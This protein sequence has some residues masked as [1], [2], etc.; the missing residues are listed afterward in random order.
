MTSNTW[1]WQDTH[2]TATC[3]SYMMQGSPKS[4][5]ICSIAMPADATDSMAGWRD[6][7]VRNTCSGLGCNGVGLCGCWW[8]ARSPASMWV[9][10]GSK[11]HECVLRLE[12]IA[13]RAAKPRSRGAWLKHIP[14][15][16]GSKPNCDNVVCVLSLSP[17]IATGS[18]QW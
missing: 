16:H 10:G 15:C 3:P 7:G 4:S 12:A 13:A 14:C 2:C 5:T 9:D 6:G 8:E 11:P 17:Q 18:R 1:S